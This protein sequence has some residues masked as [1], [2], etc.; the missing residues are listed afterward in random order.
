ME[1][2]KDR[3]S[4][5]GW[6]AKVLS[7][8]SGV[9]EPVISRLL[10]GSANIGVANIFKLLNALELLCG[11]TISSETINNQPN[12]V[13]IV[14]D[15]INADPQDRNDGDCVI[16]RIAGPIIEDIYYIMDHGADAQVERIRRTIKELRI[17]I[18][19]G[20]EGIEAKKKQ[21]SQQPQM[22]KVLPRAA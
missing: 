7:K 3:M 4:T 14:E 22:D 10:N 16:S 20:K 15:Q 12:T 6:K 1:L 8:K 18:N 9:T 19:S 21:E 11:P 17:E 5:L 2:I 13:E